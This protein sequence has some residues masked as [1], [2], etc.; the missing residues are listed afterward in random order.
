MPTDPPDLKIDLSAVRGL[1]STFCAIL[2]RDARFDGYKSGLASGLERGRREAQTEIDGLTYERGRDDDKHPAEPTH[3]D[4]WDRVLYVPTWGYDCDEENT[5]GK[6]FSE[7]QSEATR[8]SK[9][10]AHERAA[11]MRDGGE[12]VI[13]IRLR[14]RSAAS[15]GRRSA[16]SNSARRCL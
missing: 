11:W 2:T 10:D 12:N 6:A 4:Q 7:K 3:P 13:V 8:R 5:G 1:T 15:D 16:A 14:P 9:Q